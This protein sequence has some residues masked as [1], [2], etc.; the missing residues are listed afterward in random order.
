ME[1]SQI[2]IMVP[3]TRLAKHP[4]EDG[5]LGGPVIEKKTRIVTH[6]QVTD[7]GADFIVELAVGG[8][9]DGHPDNDPYVGCY[10]TGFEFFDISAYRF[11]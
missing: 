6:L 8:A 1:S 2:V 4:T 7:V 5:T 9:H 11:L 10:G 3:C